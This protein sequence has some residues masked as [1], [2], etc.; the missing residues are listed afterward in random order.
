MMMLSSIFEVLWQNLKISDEP[1]NIA[2]NGVLCDITDFY[3]DGDIME[4]VMVLTEGYEYKVKENPLKENRFR[5]HAS[6]QEV[7]DELT[8]FVYHCDNVEL[9]DLLNRV[10]NRADLNAEKYY[11]LKKKVD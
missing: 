5:Y 1:V 2:I 9:V 4:Y 6:S 3:F 8:G 10:N 7:R 11:G